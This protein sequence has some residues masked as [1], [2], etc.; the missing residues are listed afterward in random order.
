[1]GEGQKAED[2]KREPADGGHCN[3]KKKDPQSFDTL[4]GT[5]VARGTE[6]E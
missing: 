2:G 3:G 4:K 6:G 5:N 1:M